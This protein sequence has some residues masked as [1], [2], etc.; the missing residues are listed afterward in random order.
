MDGGIQNEVLEGLVDMLFPQSCCL[1]MALHCS[2]DRNDHV[3]RNGWIVEV[4]GPPFMECMIRSN[5]E[6]LTWERGFS[7]RVNHVQTMDD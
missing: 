1:W 3:I 5:I 7:K 4:L 6:A 2:L